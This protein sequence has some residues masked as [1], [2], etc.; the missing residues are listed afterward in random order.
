MLEAWRQLEKGVGQVRDDLDLVASLDELLRSEFD[1]PEFADLRELTLPARWHPRYYSTAIIGSYGVVERFVG[2]LVEGAAGLMAG[3]ASSYPDLPESFRSRHEEQSLRAALALLEGRSRL[4][5]STEE[6]VANLAACLAS[7]DGFT[8][9]QSVLALSSA[10]FRS[11]VIE[12]TVRDL[13]VEGMTGIGE[14]ALCRAALDGVLGGIYADAQSVLDDLANRRNEVSHGRPLPELL[15]LATLRG[16]VDV[17]EGYLKDLFRIVAK[18]VGHWCVARQCSE[19][20]MIEHTWTHQGTGVRSIVRVV[21]VA[22]SVLGVGNEIIATGGTAKLATMLSIQEGG[23]G[24]E[25]FVGDGQTAI[26]ID[27]G[28]PVSKGQRLFSASDDDLAVLGVLRLLQL[29]GS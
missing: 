10:N 11:Q 29:P 18:V 14:N 13:G 25:E 7:G 8:V 3:A 1:G 20:G 2:D 24:L 15:D 6:L 26:G 19:I 12:R 4:E 27:L 16:L 22:G 5:A 17:V 9:N 21:P 28:H 23:V